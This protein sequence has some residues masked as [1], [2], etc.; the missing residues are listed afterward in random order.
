MSYNVDHLRTAGKVTVLTTLVGVFALVVIF[1]FNVG[2]NEVT[3]VVA[4]ENATTSVTVLNI[5]PF[6]TS[7]TTELIE[8]S[9]D[10]PTDEGG[11][12]SWVAVG[13]D[14]NGED[15]YLLICS[16]DS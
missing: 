8:S 15:Y 3:R 6:W 10:N 4:Q 7:T 16:T 9:S 13:T 11:T 1:L 2:H 12:V 5:P 14:S